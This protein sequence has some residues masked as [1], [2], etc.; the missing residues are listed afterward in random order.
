MSDEN[1]CCIRGVGEERYAYFRL[2]E[3][4]RQAIKTCQREKYHGPSGSTRKR[5]QYL[6][7]L[8][9]GLIARPFAW[10]LERN[11]IVWCDGEWPLSDVVV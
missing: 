9:I 1:P 11:E 10:T 5:K 4:K 3:E 2:P 8:Q 7:A 6:K